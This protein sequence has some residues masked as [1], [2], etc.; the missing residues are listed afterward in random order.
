[1][2]NNIHI[3]SVKF[4]IS[5]YLVLLYTFIYILSINF[6]T[7]SKQD[8]TTL[9][10]IGPKSAEKLLTLRKILEKSR[11]QVTCEDLASVALREEVWSDLITSKTLIIDRPQGASSTHSKDS[12][13]SDLRRQVRD[14][15]IDNDLLHKKI[16]DLDVRMDK[17]D[18]HMGEMISRLDSKIDHKFEALSEQLAMLLARNE[19]SQT[20]PAY[21]APSQPKESGIRPPP[22]FNNLNYD[23]GRG[24]ELGHHTDSKS[25]YLI[26]QMGIILIPVLLI[27]WL[28]GISSNRMFPHNNNK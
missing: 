7:A 22:G 4:Q 5:G 16:G 17:M 1:V 26:N 10:G 12:D 3:I 14:I 24:F 21:T 8:F 23:M 9:E 11:A 19:P 13:I 25:V 28:V 6:W 27:C 18:H 20:P 15:S 2:Y